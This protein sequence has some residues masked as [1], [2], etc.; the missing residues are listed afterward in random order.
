[1]AATL[2][3]AAIEDANVVMGVRRE[4]VGAIRW[5]ETSQSGREK[6]HLEAQGQKQS[7][8][9]FGSFWIG[10]QIWDDTEKTK[11]LFGRFKVHCIPS[12]CLPSGF[13][14]SLNQSWN[15]TCFALYK[16][17]KMSVFFFCRM[18]SFSSFKSTFKAHLEI[19]SQCHFCW[20]SFSHCALFNPTWGG[21]SRA[22]KA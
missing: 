15:H 5:G 13:Q 21:G 20:A 16:L 17:P 2:D 7:S 11:G 19:P 18:N 6:W 10:P 1:M 4:S 8:M 12:S 14:P 9:Y 22:K 3:N